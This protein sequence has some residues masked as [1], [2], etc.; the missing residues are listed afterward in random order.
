MNRNLSRWVLV[1][2]S[3]A[4]LAL[5]LPGWSET[6]PNKKAA[7]TKPLAEAPYAAGVRYDSGNRRDPFLNPLRLKKVAEDLNE[8]VGRGAPPPGISG[9]YIAEVALL[10]VSLRD[11]G[12]TAV[13]RGPDKRAYFLQPGDKLFDGYLREIGPDFVVLIRETRL[14]SGKVLTQD[15]QK[16]L[17]TP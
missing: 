4:I 11:D 15:V 13:V 17:R 10:G 14:K 1:T 5:P 8:E 7:P 16:R 12:R 6:P 3:L 2:S 9:M